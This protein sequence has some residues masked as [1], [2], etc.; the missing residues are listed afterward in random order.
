MA[1]LLFYRQK[2]VDGGVRTG[3]DLDREEIAEHF[4]EGELER[5]PALLWYVDLRCDGPGVPADG[6]AALQWLIDYAPV[7]REGFSDT[8]R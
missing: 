5:D 7:I 8:P 1:Q 6:E 3:L 4:E 2:R